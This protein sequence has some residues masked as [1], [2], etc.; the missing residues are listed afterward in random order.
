MLPTAKILVV[1]DEV[2]IRASLK[3]MLTRDGHQVVTAES[4]E[5]IHPRV[6]P[7]ID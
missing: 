1:D 6:R 4:G 5:A 3:E 2:N 7:G